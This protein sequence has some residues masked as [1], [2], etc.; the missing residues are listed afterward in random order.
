MQ[1]YLLIT[2]MRGLK[3]R[4]KALAC[5][6]WCRSLVLSSCKLSRHRDVPANQKH[7]QCLTGVYDRVS[8]CCGCLLLTFVLGFLCF[9]GC[10]G[11]AGSDLLEGCAAVEESCEVRQGP[12]AVDPT[13]WVAAASKFV[14]APQHEELLGKA[15]SREQ[16][17]AAR[18]LLK[19]SCI[20]HGFQ[21]TPAFMTPAQSCTR[22][23]H[24]SKALQLRTRLLRRVKAT[25]VQGSLMI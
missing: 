12:E 23:L 3:R 18:W 4:N 16:P 24:T 20:Q 25:A 1:N 7:P 11:P 13:Q 2:A 14:P 15:G 17:R 8:A 5:G 10:A 19:T 6:K 22:H 21:Q 9:V